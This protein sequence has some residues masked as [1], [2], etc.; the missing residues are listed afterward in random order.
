MKIKDRIYGGDEIKEEVLID[1]INSKSF[2][3]L[4]GISQQGPP[5]QYW[6]FPIYSRFEHSL[7]V[8]LLLRK[9]GAG[10]EEQIAG[11]LHDVSHTAFSHVIDWIAGDPSKED[12]QDKS[13]FEIIG[14]SDVC[15]ILRRYNFNPRR[16]SHL[17]NFKL[18]E[19]E[20]PELCVD[21]FD[22]AVRDFFDKRSI[23]EI[24]NSLIV[25][26]GLLM[27]NSVL[28][29]KKFAEGYVLCQTQH[30]ATDESKARYFLL[31]EVLKKSLS[32]GY[33]EFK[34]LLKTD[35]EVMDLIINRGDEEINRILNLLKTPLQIT[36]ALEHDTSAITL[37]KKA[38]FV[39]PKIYHEGKVNTLSELFPYYKEILESQKINSFRRIKIRG[40]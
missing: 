37:K 31:A 6:H 18:L 30:W 4:R 36:E 14:N 19:Q 2:Q 35:A 7:G 15:P 27:F 21:R 24:V 17:E 38:R 34:D 28:S 1:L 26:K 9:V 29:A 25:R 22:Y 13:H 23:P 12:R 5:Q 20:I 3:R 39:D 33:I 8:L 11:V 16:I 32:K 10:L 40:Y